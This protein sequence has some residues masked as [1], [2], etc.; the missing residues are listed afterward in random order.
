M[1]DTSILTDWGVTGTGN[2]SRERGRTA[3]QSPTGKNIRV[4][5]ILRGA[6]KLRG[7]RKQEKIF[8]IE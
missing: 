3:H 1:T 6:K 7:M 8:I 4:R 2:I 5:R